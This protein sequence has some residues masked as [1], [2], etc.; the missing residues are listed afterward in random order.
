MIPVA[1]RGACFSACPRRIGGYPGCTDHEIAAG[2]PQRKSDFNLFGQKSVTCP[3]IYGV[4]DRSAQGHF[5]RE[6][7]KSEV[8]PL[9]GIATVNEN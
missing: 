1:K 8:E 6:N 9:V 3:G 7:R 5:R 4:H 2:L